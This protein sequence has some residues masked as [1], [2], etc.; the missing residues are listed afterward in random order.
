M[1][2]FVSWGTP[3]IK[4]YCQSFSYPVSSLSSLLLLVSEW[5]VWVLV[6]KKCSPVRLHRPQCGQ[7]WGCSSRGFS[8]L[9]PRG[10]ILFRWTGIWLFSGPMLY[11]LFWLYTNR[12]HSSQSLHTYKMW[13][14]QYINKILGFTL[15]GWTY[16]LWSELCWWLIKPERSD[17]HEHVFK[18]TQPVRQSKQNRCSVCKKTWWFWLIVS[19]HGPGG[20][21]S[22][23]HIGMLEL[24]LVTNGKCNIKHE[25]CLNQQ[26][27]D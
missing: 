8:E 4:T 22:R 9:T 16:H 3:R 12:T 7:T 26:I 5:A 13:R 24:K 17:T 2:V 25:M 10:C 21:S 6:V 23:N 20:R 19:L 27:S 1:V 14:F 15:R 18:S 11:G